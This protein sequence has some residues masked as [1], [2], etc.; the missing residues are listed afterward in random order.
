MQNK[1][2]IL[3]CIDNGRLDEVICDR[4]F[5]V[6]VIE[7]DLNDAD[8]NTIIKYDKLR[9]S[10]YITFAYSINKL[11]IDKVFKA[12]AKQRKKIK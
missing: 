2:K 7:T 3:V 1:V 5:E 8:E 9:W 10:Y 6:E 4:P 11:I 12:I